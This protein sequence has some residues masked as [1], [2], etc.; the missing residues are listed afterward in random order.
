MTQMSSSI[1]QVFEPIWTNYNTDHGLPSSETYEILQDKIGYIWIST[2][3]GLSR[4]DGYNFKNYGPINGLKDPVVFHLQED[5]SGKIWMNSL[6]KNIYFIKDD[7]IKP[8]NYNSI[9]NKYYASH[10]TIEN[11]IISNNSLYY[12]SKKN[13]ILYINSQGKVN[14]LN[15]NYFPSISIFTLNNKSIVSYEKNEP[16]EKLPAI[17]KSSNKYFNLYFIS[18]TGVTKTSLLINFKKIK[19]P[20]IYNLNNNI[21]ILSVNYYIYIFK[22]FKLIKSI[23]DPEGNLISIFQDDIGNIYSCNNNGKG[24]R[25]YKNLD[26]FLIGNYQTYLNGES[27]SYLIKD[28]NKGFWA[29]TINNGIF[30]AKDLSITQLKNATSTRDEIL[31]ISNIINDKIYLGYQSG[32]VKCFNIINSLFYDL[33]LCKSLPINDIFYNKTNKCLY[34]SNKEGTYFFKNNKWKEILLFNKQLG[35]SGIPLKKIWDKNQLNE[36]IGTTERGFFKINTKNNSS[37]FSS[38]ISTNGK[39]PF[40]RT[41]CAF[42]TLE[43]K[44]L[45]GTINGLYE[46]KHDSLYKYFYNSPSL[47]L[48]IEAIDQLNDSTLIVGTKGAGII[49]IKNGIISKITEKDGITSNMVENIFIDKKNN[50]WIGTLLG[51]NRLYKDSS[52]WKVEQLTVHNGLPSNEIIKVQS[53]N[54]NIWCL[55]TKGLVRINDRNTEK[56]SIPVIIEELYI[57]DKKIILNQELKF[58]YTDNN[59]R[60][61][62]DCLNFKMLGKIPFRFKLR[63]EDDWRETLE[64]NINLYSLAPGLYDLQIQSKNASGIWSKS[65]ILTFIILPPWWKTWEFYSLIAIILLIISGWSIY[66]R[67]KSLKSKIL[68]QKQMYELEQSAKKAQMNPHF[69]FNTLNSVQSQILTGNFEEATHFLSSFGKL[70]RDVLEM[71][72]NV[73][74]PLEIELEYLNKYL[75][76]EQMRFKKSFVFN[77]IVD[78]NID[79]QYNFIAPML[80]QPFVEN[81]IIHGISKVDQQ[82]NIQINLKKIGKF[83]EVIIIDN[84]IGFQYDSFEKKSFTKSVGISNTKRRL[85]L[86]DELKS[87]DQLKIEKILNFEGGV[88]GTKVILFIKILPPY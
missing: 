29:T 68:I 16:I 75:E 44:F 24:L 60:L 18:N 46:V 6:T 87:K 86:I 79:L 80:I 88:I 38:N 23:P 57:N 48:R 52:I 39:I 34:I 42:H 21:K 70:V 45:I 50:I 30:Y 9:L 3:N 11:F 5:N 14:T 85:E 56:S 67:I 27:V 28:R 33:P 12:E 69:L 35:F 58:S 82:G 71:S 61:K 2:D 53:N 13:G 59:I 1:A 73:S 25:V 43:N 8:Y 26:D 41:L 10:Y 32:N 19:P 66:L 31:T 40:I 20:T 47:N 83:I 15:N 54:G 81:A 55:T 63:K 37:N 74:I 65:T 84:G 62:L 36:I 49:L 22:D 17:D 4:F 51:L 7:S 72:Q 78:Q 64:R 76:L 77:I